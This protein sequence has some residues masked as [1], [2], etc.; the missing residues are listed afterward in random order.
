YKKLATL[1]GPRNVIQ[2]VSFSNDGAFVSAAGYGG[3]TIWDLNT[4]GTVATPHLP[5]E[6]KDPKHVYSSSAWL[7]FEGAD[8]Y[9][10]AVGNMAG[11]MFLWFLDSTQK[12]RTSSLCS[13]IVDENRTHQVMSMHVLEPKVTPGNL[14]R[15]VTSTSDRFVAVWT[16]T[17]N[18]EIANVFKVKLP[19]DFL[20]RTV[21]F[22][23]G[24]QN[25]LAFAKTGGGYL[26]L[27]GENGEY[28]WVKKDGL[29]EMHS[30]AVD[31]RNDMF[32]AWAGQRAELFKLSNSEHFKTFQGEVC[33]VGNTKQVVFAEDGSFLVAGTDHGFAEIFSV[34][35]ALC[36]QHLNYPRKALVQ[37]VASCTLS[38]NHLIAIAGS[39]KDQPG[40][41]VV[42]KKKR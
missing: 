10:F 34:Q 27:K 24:S 28:S 14:G 33:L 26:Q 12:A 3:V 13:Q 31:E 16:L 42:F 21:K 41:V 1:S 7:Y 23:H 5:Y 37:Y 32:A 8:K 11:E 30:V 2:S 22:L 20:P 29:P 36:V 25:V 4:S 6:P 38:T 17:S 40:D 19:A 15:I 39:T 18:L 9:V 35:S